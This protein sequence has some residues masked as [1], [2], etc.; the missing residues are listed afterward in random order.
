MTNPLRRAWLA[1]ILALPVLALSP[2]TAQA[3]ALDTISKAGTLK[4]AVPEDYPPWPR[5]SLNRW[6]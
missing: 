3:D 1:A 4:V 2:L 6:A 5:S